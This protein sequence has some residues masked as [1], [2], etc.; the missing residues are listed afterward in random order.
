MRQEARTYAWGHFALHA[1]QRMKRFTLA[2]V[3]SRSSRCSGSSAERGRYADNGS[4]MMAQGW[5][6]GG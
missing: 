5:T 3:T 4:R 2:R 1:D 6:K